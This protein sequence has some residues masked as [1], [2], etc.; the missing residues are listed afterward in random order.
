MMVAGWLACVAAGLVGGCGGTGDTE[1]APR[2]RVVATTGMIADLVRAVADPEAEVIGLIG[3]GIDPHLYNPT[4][5][6]VAQLQRADLVF[7]NG[8]MLEGKMTDVL[9]RMAAS[10][11]PVY[12][13]TD[14]MDRAYVLAGAEDGYWDPHVWMDVE[15]WQ[16]ALAVVTDALI[17]FDG[18]REVEYRA[19]AA[20]YQAQLR[21]LHEY[22]GA[23]IATIPEQ[24]RLLITA[25]D[26]FNYFG[27]AYG[28]EV[29]GIQ[30]LSTESEAGLQDINRLVDVLV[31][32]GVRA[33]FVETSVAEKNVRAL[34]EGAENRGHQVVVGGALFSDAMGAPGTYRGTYIGMID[35]NVTTIVRALGGEAPLTGLHGRLE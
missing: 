30:G 14:M 26:A 9:E 29:R 24:N 5:S 25:H 33:V 2:Y 13:V 28:I 15:A 10:G 20:A 27:R 19:R 32:R 12:A 22:A 3:E 23:V 8:L 16:L 4:R 17:A 1:E 34:I 35:H 7:Y 31:E 18:S 21:T 11:K 6:D